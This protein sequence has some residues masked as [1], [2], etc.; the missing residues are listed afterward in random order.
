MQRDPSVLVA[1]L[2]GEIVG[3]LG[4]GAFSAVTEF[5][6]AQVNLSAQST[7]S[8]KA[9]TPTL[10]SVDWEQIALVPVV[11]INGVDVRLG[12]FLPAF[13]PHDLT[14]AGVAWG[15][16]APDWT[17]ALTSTISSA[18]ELVGVDGNTVRAGQS[19]LGLVEQ[20]C[21]G[22]GMP[23]VNFIDPLRVL[24]ADRAWPVGTGIAEVV[25][26]LLDSVTFFPVRANRDGFATTAEKVSVVDQLPKADIDLDALA[27]S[28]KVTPRAS[29]VINVVVVVVED[30][31][32]ESFSARYVDDNP[33]NPTSTVRLRRR[34]VRVV[35]DNLIATVEDAASRA[36]A[37]IDAAAS[38][39]Y[40]AELSMPFDPTLDV[41]DVVRVA[42]LGLSP[43]NWRIENIALGIGADLATYRLATGLEISD[44]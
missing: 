32:R 13:Q 34:R 31:Q 6:A 18:G 19:V 43:T 22:A 10:T 2:T 44:Q 12:H 27:G 33:A 9:T 36:A 23:G 14:A 41:Y 29:A 37:E 17:D 35:K 39:L 24:A 4:E 8:I 21:L 15:M 11:G 26:E 7:F 28:L 16:N 42:G 20:L 30:P 40:S 5:K 3:T 1:D 25:G 38:L